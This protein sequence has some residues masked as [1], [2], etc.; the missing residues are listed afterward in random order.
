M[1]MRS[2]SEPCTLAFAHGVSSAPSTCLLKLCGP[3]QLHSNTTSSSQS[4]QIPSPALSP[5]CSQ[6]LWLVPPL[7][8]FHSLSSVQ[9]F[10]Y[11]PVFPEPQRG[12]KRLK[13][14]LW[15][16]IA[17]TSPVMN[18]CDLGHFM[19]PLEAPLSS[20]VELGFPFASHMGSWWI[21]VFICF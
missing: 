10:I 8:H 15:T 7:L 16:Q 14:Q 6:T 20:W 11:M 19:W 3:S 17:M 2:H 12:P 18:L 1:S 9:W 21:D 13:Q 4:F 5:T